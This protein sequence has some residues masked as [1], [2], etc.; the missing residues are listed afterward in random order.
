M[1]AFLTSCSNDESVVQEQNINESAA[2][3]ETLNRLA[4]QYTDDGYVIASENPAGNIVFDFCFDFVYPLN[5]SYNTGTIVSVDSLDDLIIILIN[6]TDDLYIN[7]IEY[8]FDV[9]VYNEATDAIEIVTISN[10]D[11]FLDLLENCDFDSIDSCEC[12]DEVNPVCVE[13]QDPTGESFIIT[14]PNECYALC[15]GFT[16]N[17]FAENCEDDYN[18]PGGNE[19]FDFNYPI[20]VVTD[21]GQ[22]ITVNSQEELDSALY[23]VYYFDFVY[24]FEVTDDEGNVITINDEQDFINLLEDC[25]DVVIGEECDECL[26]QEFN[27]VCVEVQSPNGGTEIIDFPN[28]CYAICEGFSPNDFVDCGNTGGCDCDDQEY[29]PVCVQVEEG[30]QIYTYTFPNACF[31]ECEGF[32]ASDFVDCENNNPDNCS[33]QE[34]FGFLLQCNWYINTSLYDNV[35]A[36][37]A[38]FSQ[39]GSVTIYSAGSNSGVSG[40]WDLGSNPATEE[41]YA[42]LNFN[43]DPYNAFTALD[44]TVTECSEYFI[45]LTSGNEFIMLE[46]DC[47]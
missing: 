18:C 11:E 15:D 7:G 44:W 4:Q 26:D 33:E 30:G 21:E 3:T 23:N 12:D 35:N 43:D 17:D 16:P 9:E 34:L 31:A 22:T 10:E 8:P 39:D 42:F 32:S 13:V 46:R 38:Q 40:V 37:Y 47:D 14:Y 24:P 27:P 2:I 25:F 5:L 19:C 29:D 41:V 36:E 1:T 20:T 6:S 45:V 28:A